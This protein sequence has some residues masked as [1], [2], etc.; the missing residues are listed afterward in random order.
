MRTSY[1]ESADPLGSRLTVDLPGKPKGAETSLRAPIDL[2]GFDLCSCTLGRHSLGVD[3]VGLSA[4]LAYS[5][6]YVDM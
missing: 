2:L 5:T 3:D 4:S 1:D 6:V